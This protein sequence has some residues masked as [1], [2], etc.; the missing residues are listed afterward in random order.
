MKRKKEIPAVSGPSGSK[1]TRPALKVNKARHVFTRKRTTTASS[2]AVSAEAGSE[3]A[4]ATTAVQPEKAPPKARAIKTLKRTVVGNRKK[5]RRQL[6]ALKALKPDLSKE[7]KVYRA[8]RK[9]HIDF[10]ETREGPSA[11]ARTFS[12]VTVTRNIKRRSENAG[13]VPFAGD[14]GEPGKDDLAA[15]LHPPSEP[16]QSGNRR[17]SAGLEE[18][19]PS[20]ETTES[21]LVHT[22]MAKRTAKNSGGGRTGILSKSVATAKDTPP[23]PPPPPPPSVGDGRLKKSLAK[24]KTRP[25]TKLSSSSA[26]SVAESAPASVPDTTPVVPKMSKRFSTSI[27][28]SRRKDSLGA[29]TPQRDLSPEAMQ[30]DGDERAAKDSSPLD[31]GREVSAATADSFQPEESSENVDQQGGAAAS[32]AGR[33]SHKGRGGARSFSKGRGLAGGSYRGRVAVPKGRGRGFAVATLSARSGTKLGDRGRNRRKNKWTH[34]KASK[35]KPASTLEGDSVEQMPETEEDEGIDSQEEPPPKRGRFRKEQV[36]AADGTGK[37]DQDQAASV[38][39]EEEDD[40]PEREPG[41]TRKKRNIQPPSYIAPQPRRKNSLGDITDTEAA[42]ASKMKTDSAETLK[43]KKART[44]RSVESVVR[45]RK[46]TQGQV[47]GVGHSRSSSPGGTEVQ[48]QKKGPRKA[49]ELSRSSS[50]D[51]LIYKSK[52]APALKHTRSKTF[53]S[54]RNEP[55]GNNSTDGKPSDSIADSETESVASEFKSEVP[56][57]SKGFRGSLKRKPLASPSADSLAGVKRR[58]LL[59]RLQDSSTHQMPNILWSGR[60]SRLATGDHSPAVS[61]ESS[62]G[63]VSRVKGKREPPEGSSTLLDTPMDATTEEEGKI[64]LQTDSQN[65]VPVCVDSEES[66]AGKGGRVTD[67]ADS[68]KAGGKG[69]RVIDSADSAVSAKGP[70]CETLVTL[71]RTMKGRGKGRAKQRHQDAAS[72]GKDEAKREKDEPD[73]VKDED[74]ADES[75]S[76][77]A[78]AADSSDLSFQ[79]LSSSGEDGTIR[80]RGRP[81]GSVRRRFRL[82][83]VKH[84]SVVA[85]ENFLKLKKYK[86]KLGVP[87]PGRPRKAGPLVKPELEDTNPHDASESEDTVEI[88]ALLQKTKRGRM[89]LKSSQ[90]KLDTEAVSSVKKAGGGKT[91]TALELK[92]KP[93]KPSKD[94]SGVKLKNTAQDEGEFSSEGKSDICGKV[95][96]TVK[97]TN[98]SDSEKTVA[99]SSSVPESLSCGEALPQSMDVTEVSSLPSGSVDEA[100]SST[101]KARRANRKTGMGNKLPQRKAS[102]KSNTLQTLVCMRRESRR[103]LKKSRWSTGKLP[104]QSHSALS[105]SVRLKKGSSGLSGVL[106]RSVS[107]NQKEKDEATGRPQSPIPRPSI[108]EDSEMEPSVRDESQDKVVVPCTKPS[109]PSPEQDVSSRVVTQKD[110]VDDMPDVPSHAEPLLSKECDSVPE[111]ADKEKSLSEEQPEPL[112]DELSQEAATHPASEEGSAAACQPLTSTAE[113]PMDAQPGPDKPCDDDGTQLEDL[114]PT[115]G[116]SASHQ[117]E[118]SPAVD[119][120]PSQEPSPCDQQEESSS[121]TRSEETE[122]LADQDQMAE[123]SV[124]DEKQSTQNQ[125]EEPSISNQSEEPSI[126]NQSEEPSISNPSEELSTQNQSEKTPAQDQCE[127]PSVQ[128]QVE[129]LSTHKRSEELSTEDQP[130]QVQPEPCTQDQRGEP[131]EH[132]QAQPLTELPSPSEAPTGDQTQTDVSVESGTEPQSAT[133][134]KSTEQSQSGP[135]TVD[136]D[137]TPAS[138]SSSNF[139][140]TEME[141]GPQT[142]A[143]DNTCNGKSQPQA[144]GEDP[145]RSQ[146]SA[147]QHP[148]VHPGAAEMSAEDPQTSRETS[149]TTHMDT[150]HSELP[151][152]AESTTPTKM[153]TGGSELHLPATETTACAVTE[154]GEG[155]QDLLPESSGSTDTGI[156]DSKAGVA[157]ADIDKLTETPQPILSNS[158]F[159]SC[160]DTCESDLSK[161]AET[162][163]AEDIPDM[164]HSDPST[165]SAEMDEQSP[166]T[167]QSTAENSGEQIQPSTEQS[168]EDPDKQDASGANQSTVVSESETR[169]KRLPIAKRKQ[170]AISREL[171]RLQT[172]EGAQRIMSWHEKKKLKSLGKLLRSRIKDDQD[173]AEAKEDRKPTSSKTYSIDAISDTRLVFKTG[174]SGTSGTVPEHAQKTEAGQDHSGSFDQDSSFGPALEISRRLKRGILSVSSSMDSEDRLPPDITEMPHYKDSLSERGRLEE[175]SPPPLI[176]PEDLF[177]EEYYESMA[178]TSARQHQEGKM[179]KPEMSPPG[180]DSALTVPQRKCMTDSVLAALTDFDTSQ[181]NE[182]SGA[183]CAESGPKRRKK[184]RGKRRQGKMGP[185]SKTGRELHVKP[186]PA[187]SKMARRTSSPKQD[188]SFVRTM[189]Q[190]PSEPRTF[191]LRPKTTR[192]PIEIIAMKQK[193]EEEAYELEEA[194]RVARK[195]KRRQALFGRLAMAMDAANQNLIGSCKPCSVV[196]VDFVKELHLNSID[197]SDQYISDVSYDS[198]EEDVDDEDD[199]YIDELYAKS[200]VL[201]DQGSPESAQRAMMEQEGVHG[202]AA[203]SPSDGMKTGP[204]LDSLRGKGFMGNFV[205]FI[206]NRSSQPMT[207]PQKKRMQHCSRTPGSSEGH[208]AS[209]FSVVGSLSVSCTFDSVVTSPCLTTMSTSSSGVVS[210]PSHSQF[211]ASAQIHT[212]YQS[213]VGKMDPRTVCPEGD[214]TVSSSPS[215]AAESSNLVSA[216]KPEYSPHHHMVVKSPLE[217]SSSPGKL[218]VFPARKETD[219][220]AS[221]KVAFARYLCTKCDF[222][223]TNK[224]TIESHIY[225]H[226][227]GVTFKCG[228]CESEFTGLISALTHVKNSHNSKEPKVWISK[229]IHEASLYTEEEIQSCPESLASPVPEPGQGESADTSLGDQ[230]LEGQPVIISLVVSGDRPG[231]RSERFSSSPLA[232]Q[233]RFACTHCSYSTNVVEDAHQHVRDLHSDSS[234]FT[235]YLCDKAFGWRHQDVLAHCRATHPDRPKSF[236]KLPDFYDQE[237]IRMNSGPGDRVKASEDRGNIFDRMSNFFPSLGPG[238]EMMME[239]GQMLPQARFLRARDYLYIQEGWSKKTSAEADSTTIEDVEI[240]FE[241]AADVDSSGLDST[242][243]EQ[244]SRRGLEAHEGGLGSWTQKPTLS[245]GLPRTGTNSRTLPSSWISPKDLSGTAA[246]DATR[247]STQQSLLLPLDTHQSSS[248]QGLSEGAPNASST[249]VSWAE[250]ETGWASGIKDPKDAGE[251]TGPRAGL[252]GRMMTAGDGP[253]VSV[254]HPSVDGGGS[255]GDKAP[256]QSCRKTAAEGGEQQATPMGG[257]GEGEDDGENDILVI[258]LG[259][260]VEGMADDTSHCSS[261]QE[262]TPESSFTEAENT[263]TANTEKESASLVSQEQGMLDP[264]LKASPAK[265]RS[266][267]AGEAEDGSA[268]CEETA[269][270]SMGI[271]ILSVVSLR[272]KIDQGADLSFSPVKSQSGSE[273]SSSPSPSG[274]KS[275]VRK[276]PP[277]L[278]PKSSPSKK[279]A[280]KPLPE[281]DADDVAARNE[282]MVCTY[283]CHSCSI[284]SPALAAIVEHLKQHHHNVPL[285]SCP[286]CKA[287][288]EPFFTEES[289]HTHVSDQHPSNYAK[290]EV[291]LSEIAKSFVQVLALPSGSR[292]KRSL[293]E[294]DIYMCLRCESHIPDL[295]YALRHLKYEHPGLLKYACPICG[296]YSNSSQGVVK[297]HMQDAHGQASDS[298]QLALA[299]E[300][301][302]LTKV[303]CIS[304]GGQYVDHAPPSTPPP[305]PKPS[306]KSGSET[307]TAQVPNTADGTASASGQTQ[308]LPGSGSVGPSQTCPGSVSSFVPVTGFTPLALTTAI[309]D[310]ASSFLAA[311]SG[312]KSGKHRAQPTVYSAG[313]MQPSSIVDPQQYPRPILPM[314]GSLASLIQAAR[315]NR[316]SAVT[317]KKTGVVT[318]KNLLDTRQ[319]RLPSLALDSAA[320]AALASASEPLLTDALTPRGMFPVTSQDPLGPSAG[321]SRVSFPSTYTPPRSSPAS[322]RP[323]L[324]VP[325]VSSVLDLTSPSRCSSVDTG[326]SVNTLMA[327]ASSSSSANAGKHRLSSLPFPAAPAT[328][329]GSVPASPKEREDPE[330]FKIFNLKPRTPV[331]QSPRPSVSPVVS[332]QHKPP[333]PTLLSPP[334]LRASLASNI[335]VVTM[336]SSALFPQQFRLQHFP[337]MQPAG[338]ATLPLAQG[339]LPLAQNFALPIGAGLPLTI[340]LMGPNTFPPVLVPANL[341]PQLGMQGMPV[342][343]HQLSP[344]VSGAAL[345]PPP[346]HQPIVSD[347]QTAPVNLS[348]SQPARHTA[349]APPP[350][351]PKSSKSLGASAAS[352]SFLLKAGGAFNRGRGRPRLQQKSVDQLPKPTMPGSFSPRLPAPAALTAQ[353]S[354]AS[355]ASTLAGQSE[356]P[357][358]Q[359]PKPP[360]PSTSHQCVCPYCPDQT[361]LRPWEV[362]QHIKVLHPGLEV[363]YNRV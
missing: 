36:A 62:P 307:L 206:Q 193:L 45:D 238:S 52:S 198:D 212:P 283:K 31:E 157:P 150:C 121:Q 345:P 75:L 107:E 208:P 8:L 185:A 340:P 263:K 234:L 27:Y 320:L 94:S 135:D 228:Y 274:K 332:A 260:D 20:E 131:S 294:E 349:S 153:E 41:Q 180:T 69:G 155:H 173:E 109:C 181:E 302:Y 296:T 331:P 188:P 268:Q 194:T 232:S 30:V 328:L 61:R 196:L 38:A 191:A 255:C 90:M 344:M 21:A 270:D 304:A 132:D 46:W 118:H 92:K 347:V 216:E 158:A 81:K 217:K 146:L 275:V 2:K 39:E 128:D 224:G 164:A 136:P 44:C 64:L 139:K 119:G 108:T 24:S 23:P 236:K 18:S 84:H 305:P 40:L 95:S 58:R 362:A 192:S 4:E 271:K 243:G 269:E 251:D 74:T 100:G 48:T 324:R 175:L 106:G 160:E 223:A 250:P 161:T 111:L 245:A 311:S 10:K 162:E 143:D 338:I 126:S 277:S 246:E 319:K 218:K 169:T 261:P 204:D 112:G 189:S 174:K 29:S 73:R 151:A 37:E 122:E 226:I 309:Q 26:E 348:L 289:V 285:F 86:S 334:S 125:S 99:V 308:S 248:E 103:Q 210:V 257:E 200:M 350:Q 253:H 55:A 129:M 165:V 264:G 303:V 34:R 190:L 22:E 211:V 343:V 278:T 229:D 65:T 230:P 341:L 53:Q 11:L 83:H 140:P 225:R 201:G 326:T 25:R 262:E 297:K 123:P 333:P 63:S 276:S 300:G 171:K 117:S 346:A 144:E 249:L 28:S 363:K 105:S 142:H 267:V 292:V 17:T 222:S 357:P 1:K 256:G 13:A 186:G 227:P 213:Q 317:R 359:S 295:D 72:R 96:E 219:G 56:R 293:I 360:R 85:M 182:A 110:S 32:R 354:Q 209:S 351:I 154:T 242:L 68:D 115:A 183:F 240:P 152:A 6:A 301:V 79:S 147:G 3:A 290:N 258:D 16:T 214:K 195:L 15:G 9:L 205:D 337:Q 266:G 141:D 336:A 148:E 358:P 130:M 47:K 287:R 54:R 71:A 97:A 43:N 113:D 149:S 170:K 286:Y 353:L 101:V 59:T 114:V 330:A 215:Q 166:S 89:P 342:S 314:P 57:K 298:V 322:S 49:G 12:S 312:Q 288:K 7:K 159:K 235:C 310:P 78:A 76:A 104:K 335:P 87:L 259:E 51:N 50:L 281:V 207:L 167:E 355:L 220:A 284:H 124:R 199:D 299:M 237:L 82:N 323:V 42:A 179:T 318:V 272:D 282:R 88:T 327:G 315:K 239:D 137:R 313:S 352:S 280:A 203:S 66:K 60:S 197:T 127:K 187:S 116:L 321:P 254:T 329:A 172:D 265:P 252:G 98:D 184:G 247:L 77:D 279:K 145:V 316:D 221:E 244:I 168:A 138:V 19:L 176:R 202:A 133:L 80:R 361:I 93:E 91:S 178:V 102:E 70:P 356:P 134:T 67:S 177:S 306:A 156:C 231:Q 163:G 339:G 120:E 35:T 325:N 241:D 33:G 14:S 233:R 273:S 291:S 5:R